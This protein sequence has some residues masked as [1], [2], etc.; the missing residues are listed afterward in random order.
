VFSVLSEK[1]KICRVDSIQSRVVFPRR[2]PRHPVAA[3]GTVSDAHAG[4]NEESGLATHAYCVHGTTT[5]RPAIGTG[6]GT[7]TDTDTNAFKP[8]QNLSSS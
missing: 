1:H 5:V 6:T 8:S 4:A 7:G 2:Y 3:T